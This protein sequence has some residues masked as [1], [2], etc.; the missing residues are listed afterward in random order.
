MDHVHG[1]GAIYPTLERSLS[2]RLRDLTV[3]A[4]Q[5]AS[6]MLE[7][8]GYEAVDLGVDGIAQG[9][10]LRALQLMTRSGN[11]LYGGYLVAVSLAHLALHCGDSDQAARLA[12]AGLRGTQ[13]QATPAVRAAFRTVL[14][15]AHARRGDE[16]ACT[17]AL[18]QVDTDLARSRTDEEPHWI[19]YF[20]E[21]DLADEKAHCF[22]DLGRY[23][24]AYQETQAAL[25]LLPPDRA[26]RVCIDS[27]LQAAAL[28]RAHQVEHACAV[29]RRAIDTATGVTSFRAAHRI[30][31]MLAEL[32]PY[33]DVPAVQDVV[34]YA[35]TRLPPI[36]PAG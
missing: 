31:L 27:A 16:A 35:H 34:E 21:A 14:A 5:V 36:I 22:F 17:A 1:A 18:L 23:E 4:P 32:H 8:A 9:H 6:G 11:T 20:G 26:R 25:C 15:R 7:L 10:H 30:V 24:Q 2:G 12:V 29:A 19:R 3:T 33:A 13:A 28:A